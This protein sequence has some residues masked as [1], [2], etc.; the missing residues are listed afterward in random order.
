[1]GQ[2]MK[3]NFTLL[4]GAAVLI[5]LVPHAAVA[6]TAAVPA[7]YKG[8]TF[9]GWGFNKA[10]LDKSVKPATISS[11][12]STAS[13]SRTRSSRR[14]ILTAAPR[15]SSAS[16]PNA[17]CARSSKKWRHANIRPAA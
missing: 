9:P 10:D 16:A 6:Q 7:E 3:K 13:G 2:I 17:M 1:M 14:N 5:A 12:T 8:M 11:N 4:A 15:C